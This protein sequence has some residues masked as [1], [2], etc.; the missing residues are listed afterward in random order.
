MVKRPIDTERSFGSIADI[1]MSKPPVQEI[2]S[3]QPLPQGVSSGYEPQQPQRLPFLQRINAS[4]QQQPPTTYV[5]DAS[6]M[7]AYNA[8]VNSGDYDAQQRQQA[9]I[10]EAQMQQARDKAA[11]QGAYARHNQ[12]PQGAASHSSQVPTQ[13]ANPARTQQARP[14]SQ[15]VDGKSRKHRGRN[16]LIALTGVAVLSGVGYF[17]A[18]TW[19]P[20]YLPGGNNADVA[21][22]APATTANPEASATQT[23]NGAETNMSQADTALAS[24]V[25]QALGC[26]DPVDTTVILDVLAEVIPQLP[27]ADGYVVPTG[28]YVAREEGDTNLAYHTLRSQDKEKGTVLGF[29]A[30]A[31]SQQTIKVSD[32][33]VSIDRNSLVINAA[34]KGDFTVDK[35]GDLPEFKGVDKAVIAEANKS[36]ASPDT[37]QAIGHTVVAEMMS[38]LNGAEG[39]RVR[40]GIEVDITVT[41]SKAIA[42]ASDIDVKT[43]F[44]NVS[45]TGDID[46]MSGSNSGIVKAA[47]VIVASLKG[48]SDATVD[49]A[50]S[51]LRT[52]RAI[53]VLQKVKES[54]VVTER[55]AS[56]LGGKIAPQ[57]ITD[58]LN[59]YYE[60]KLGA[61]IASQAPQDSLY[62]ANVKLIK[63]DVIGE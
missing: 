6:L 24:D 40:K 5:V 31:P 47:N 54:K 14:A 17:S 4:E 45:F 39:D 19:A 29:T 61:E 22:A 10:H 53:E 43:A 35:L 21:A 59:V 2:K 37:T 46:M 13:Q 56:V 9:R 11:G 32:G 34:P 36:L 62:V 1:A 28:A 27:T 15:E 51:I 60:Q 25:Y 38:R 23:A 3:E 49:D 48:K 20:E 58:V 55:T 26:T 41:A 16:F 44:D 8:V 30:C 12:R 52:A 33:K 50:Q 57:V 42:N 18:K 63:M 7:A